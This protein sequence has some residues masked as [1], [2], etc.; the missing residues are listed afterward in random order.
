[1]PETSVPFARH[2]ELQPSDAA[3]ASSTAIAS[4]NCSPL[5][6]FPVA[7]VVSVLDVT[8]RHYYIIN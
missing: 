6:C 4:F 1:M 3:I 8:I 2:P 7:K 5:A